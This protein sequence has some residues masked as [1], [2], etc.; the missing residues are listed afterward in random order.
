MEGANG[1]NKISLWHQLNETYPPNFLSV[2]LAIALEEVTF[3]AMSILVPQMVKAGDRIKT[4]NLPS[5]CFYSLHY[6]PI[7]CNGSS[8][9]MISLPCFNYESL[10]DYK[11]NNFCEHCTSLKCTSQ[12]CIVNA[13]L[14][15]VSKQLSTVNAQKGHRVPRLGEGSHCNTIHVQ[16]CSWACKTGTEILS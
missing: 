6:F 16:L 2:K 10:T 1:L 15:K 7:P 9:S 3:H 11:V 8:K 14:T 5:K 12:C 13:V 4:I